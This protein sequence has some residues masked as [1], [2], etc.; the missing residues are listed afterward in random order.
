MP[1]MYCPMCNKIHFVIQRICVRRF[2]YKGHT[3][4]YNARTYMCKES[5]VGYQLFEDSKMVF[6]NINKIKVAI[7]EFE[8]D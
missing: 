3:L 4:K 2:K 5:P 1:E 8:N 7:E 6:E